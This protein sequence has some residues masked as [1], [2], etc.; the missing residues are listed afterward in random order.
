MGLPRSTFYDAPVAPADDAEIV[1]RMVAIVAELPPTEAQNRF[2]IVFMSFVK[3]V[4]Q[5]T[6]AARDLHGRPPMERRPDAD[7]PGRRQRWTRARVMSP[8]AGS[9]RRQV[10]QHR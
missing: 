1:A 7:R 3:R 8:V 4:R 2:Q 6:A 5:R 9:R 10:G